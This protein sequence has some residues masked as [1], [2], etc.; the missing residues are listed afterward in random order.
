[1]LIVELRLLVTF[2]IFF[3]L[4][5]LTKF[6]VMHIGYFHDKKQG[7]SFLLPLLLIFFS[8]SILMIRFTTLSF[9]NTVSSI[10]DPYFLK[11]IYIFSYTIQGKFFIIYFILLHRPIFCV[12]CILISLLNQLVQLIFTFVLHIL[13]QLTLHE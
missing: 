1:M 6:S 5:A 7:L 3:M 11:R 9:R 12:F 2:I 10:L 8:S 4:L 13:N